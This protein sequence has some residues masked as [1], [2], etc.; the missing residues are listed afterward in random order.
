MS[1]FFLSSPSPLPTFTMVYIAFLTWSWP[2]VV[3]TWSTVNK[4]SL[5]SYLLNSLGSQWHHPLPLCYL[6]WNLMTEKFNH[7]WTTADTNLAIS[8]CKQ[9][10]DFLLSDYAIL[11][12]IL[13][14]TEVKLGPIVILFIK[15]SLGVKQP[16]QLLVLLKSTLTQTSKANQSRKYVPMCPTFSFSHKD[17]EASQISPFAI[18]ITRA[19]HTCFVAKRKR[20]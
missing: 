18:R 3:S 19:A 14:N 11:D 6:F 9:D 4:I 2:H 13:K 1:R 16:C 7:E 20:L 12:V 15:L 8:K 17:L 10:C 5:R